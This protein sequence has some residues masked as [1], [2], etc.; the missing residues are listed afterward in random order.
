MKRSMDIYMI[1]FEKAAKKMA[2]APLNHA[3]SPVEAVVGQQNQE[4]RV[5]VEEIADPSLS[6]PPAPPTSNPPVYDINLLPYDRGERLSIE[7]YHV[8]DQDAIRR[9][10]ITKGPCK[11][12]IHDFPYRNIVDAPRRFGL[13][14]LYNQE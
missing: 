11:P 7:N 2:T 4:D 13:T 3:P 5:K 1:S 8:H 10:Y 14:W 9:A 12:Y 6:P